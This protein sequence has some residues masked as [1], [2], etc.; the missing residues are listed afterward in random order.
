MKFV[1]IHSLYDC[2]DVLIF[3]KFVF[4]LESLRNFVIIQ[5]ARIKELEETVTLLTD[6]KK[7]CERHRKREGKFL[8]SVIQRCRGDNVPLTDTS[9][10]DFC[11]RN[12]V[13]LFCTFDFIF[14]L[15]CFVGKTGSL[16]GIVPD[17]S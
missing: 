2:F 1:Q 17:S 8:E 7:R 16:Q 4:F 12:K 5:E 11:D 6:Q 3:V 9:C 13:S 14:F 10:Q 15:N